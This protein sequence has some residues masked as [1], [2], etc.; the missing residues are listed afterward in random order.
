M[1]RNHQRVLF[2]LIL[3]G[4]LMSAR[5][6]LVL[7][8]FSAA[9]PIKIMAVGDSITDDGVFNGAWRLYLQPLLEANG[10]PFTFVG[11]NQSMPSG[12]F[13][14]TNHEGYSGAVIAPP[15]VLNY[16]VHGYAGTN[17]Y[18]QKIVADALTNAT[19]DLVLVM[20]GVNDIGRGRDPYQV[21]TNDMPNL[22]DLVFSNAPNA[23]VILAKVTSLYGASLPAL[24]TPP[25]ATNISTYNA[26]LQAMVNQRRALGQKVSL[27]DM[28]SVVDIDTMFTS[29]MCIRMRWACRPS[30]RNGSPAS[31]P[32]P[33]PP[34]GDGHADPWRRR[35]EILRHRPGPGNELVPA[36]LRRQRLGQ[37][38]GAAGL[39]RPGGVHDRQLW[40]GCDQPLYH[41]LFSPL[42]YRPGNGTFTN[43]NFRLTRVDGAWFGSTA[44]KLFAPTCRPDRSPVRTWH[45]KGRLRLE[46]ARRTF[47]T[48]P[49]SRCRI[50]PRER[51]WSR[52]KFICSKPTE[53]PWALTWN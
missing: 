38:T 26:A 11:R 33:S 19:P 3:L 48:R 34:T 7:A 5:G 22:L 47:S 8:N 31:R 18:L 15:G 52:W 39:R 36:Q 32:S 35:L 27:A 53:T 29:D 6:E 21:A 1:P 23:N 10:Y 51:T 30:R 16:A 41:H 14:K 45:R 50:C 13:T 4:A 24:T 49:T 17:V 37:R 9:N 46:W 28:F 2:S 40:A 44:R 20:I 12:N 42:V 43:L 25:T